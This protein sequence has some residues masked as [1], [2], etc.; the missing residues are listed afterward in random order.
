MNSKRLDLSDALLAVG[1]IVAVTGVALFDL[2]VAVLVGGTALIAAGVL[3]GI[4]Q[5]GRRGR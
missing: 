5:G 1:L 4:S 3:I 2:R